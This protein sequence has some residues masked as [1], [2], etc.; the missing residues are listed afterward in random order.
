MP[1]LGSDGEGGTQSVLGVSSTQT[2]AKHERERYST[3]ERACNVATS[4]QMWRTARS[5]RVMSFECDLAAAAA[6]AV[7]VISSSPLTAALSLSLCCVSLPC[8]LSYV[9]ITMTAICMWMLSVD[10]GR[11]GCMRDRCCCCCCDAMLTRCSSVLCAVPCCGQLGHGLV[12]AVAPA[13]LSD[14][15]NERLKQRRLPLLTFSLP[16]VH[17]AALPPPPSLSFTKEFSPPLSLF[18]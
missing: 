11:A 17:S 8:S 18:H 10:T 9:M 6:E 3:M 16:P 14:S 4:E 2:A 12:D 5:V 1:V 15:A 13:H 7:A